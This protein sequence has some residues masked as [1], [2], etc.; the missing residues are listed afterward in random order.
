M[1]YTLTNEVMDQYLQECK[2]VKELNPHT[3]KAYQI[4]LNQFFAF[5][6]SFDGILQKEAL[7]AYLVEL[8]QLYQKPKTVKRKIASI[9]A[10]FT[11][12]VFHDL[13]DTN[14]LSK[15][16]TSFREPRLLPRT[17][18]THHLS[19]I[20]QQVYADIQACTTPYQ[21][22]VRIR[23][24]AVM[25]LLFSTGIRV[26]ELCHVKD[27]EL[28]LK[29]Q[30][31]RIYGKG[32][33]ERILQIGNP[34]VLRILRLYRSLFRDEILNSGFFF[35]NRL[36]HPLS[37]QSVRLL[38]LHYEKT[39]HLPQHITPHMFRHTFATQLLEED[40]DIRYIQHI[41]G[42]SSI[43]T[44]QIYTHISSNKQREILSKKNPRNTLT[45]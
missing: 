9:N 30:Y 42:H 38:L 6:K 21:K 17:I 14:P 19:S 8:H 12:L 3:L 35:I 10:F 4:D 34:D 23:N 16:R 40:V 36:G 43:T 32:A 26:S 33:K 15:L 31:V 28:N 45:F 27:A 2:A 22:K 44:T 37:E 25:E 11:Y 18:P 7:H 39:L 24:A 5:M 29:D 20:F 13:L 1:S 41:L